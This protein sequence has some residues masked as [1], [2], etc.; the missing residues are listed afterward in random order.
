MFNNR[1]QKNGP[2]SRRHVL[3]R[4]ITVLLS[5]LLFGNLSIAESAEELVSFKCARAIEAALAELDE[6]DEQAGN[7]VIKD[8]LSK[9]DDSNGQLV[10]IPMSAKEI[11][12]R[13]QSTDMGYSD[14]RLVFSIDAKT[15]TVL[16]TFYGR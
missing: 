16:K 2:A 8:V 4:L 12:V 1:Q 10:C 5:G 9:I 3:R 15:Y 11:Q 7:L 6:L 13:L 14:N